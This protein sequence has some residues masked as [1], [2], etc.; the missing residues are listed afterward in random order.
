MIMI[1]SNT[2]KI[3]EANVPGNHNTEDDKKEAIL[4]ALLLYLLF[5]DLFL[6]LLKVMGKKK[7]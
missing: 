2:R 5:I 6:K 1:A 4:G 3:K 7:K